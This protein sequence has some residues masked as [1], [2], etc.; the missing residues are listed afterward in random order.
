MMEIDFNIYKKS[1][2]LFACLER[3]AALSLCLDSLLPRKSNSV[4]HAVLNQH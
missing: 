4:C 1:K 3:T 2:P